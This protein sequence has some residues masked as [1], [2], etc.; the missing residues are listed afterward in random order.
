VDDEVV[1]QLKQGDEVEYWIILG[2]RKITRK[3]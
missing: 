2:R 3:K 1:G